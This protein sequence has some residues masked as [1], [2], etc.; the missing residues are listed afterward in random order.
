MEHAS[1]ILDH[2]ARNEDVFQEYPVTITYTEYSQE[3]A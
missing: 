2:L 1:E 3:K